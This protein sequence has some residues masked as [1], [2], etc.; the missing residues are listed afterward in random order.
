[1]AGAG[2]SAGKLKYWSGQILPGFL[3]V[4]FPKSFVYRAPLKV[5]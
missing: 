3:P 5:M 2:V 4:E 1:M